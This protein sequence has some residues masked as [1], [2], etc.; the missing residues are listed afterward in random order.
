MNKVQ[1][2]PQAVRD[3]AELKQYVAVE[4]GNP[5]AAGKLLSRITRE[6]RILQ[7]HPEAGPSIEAITGHP[8]DLRMLVCAKHIAIYRV[9]G[10]IVSVA[11]IISAR[12][13]YMRVL[14]GDPE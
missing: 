2:T 12:Q 1:L 4:L 14:F 5:S 9:N 11:R 6:L 13:D 8:T 3:L 10:S 7:H